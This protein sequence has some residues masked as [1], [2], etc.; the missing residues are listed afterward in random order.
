[1]KDYKE[2]KDP[3]TGDVMWNLSYS[4]KDFELAEKFITENYNENYKLSF[5]DDVTKD[6]LEI[7]NSIEEIKDKIAE[8]VSEISAKENTFAHFICVDSTFKRYV[9]GVDFTRG[10]FKVP[11]TYTYRNGKISE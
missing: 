7:T 9:I 8:I 5:F 3:I 6:V 1:M 4:E 10:Y 11:G 2:M